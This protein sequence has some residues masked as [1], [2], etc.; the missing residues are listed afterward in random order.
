MVSTRNNALTRAPTLESLDD[1]IIEI[2]ES[3]NAF[4]IAQN[5]VS[6]EINKPKSGEG[7]S[8]PDGGSNTTRRDQDN[9]HGTYKYGWI[10]KIKFPKFSG[11]DVKGWLSR[12]NQF[13][14][15]DDV[16]DRNKV[17]L[18]SM[19]VSLD[20]SNSL[21]LQ[22]DDNNSG[23]LISLK[24]T[25]SENY[26]VWTNAMKIAL[27]A[28]NKMC[29][30]DG[31]CTK[32]AYVTSVS[33]S[34]QWEGCNA[35]VLSWLL[36]SISDDLYL[37]QVYY[38][39]VVEFDILTKL[40]PCTCDAKTELGKHNQL[41]KLMQFLMGL[42]DVYLPIRSSLL[43]QTE[44][45]DVKDAFV[46]VCREESHIG[47]GCFEIIG[48][49]NSFKRNQNG[50][51]SSN[52]KGYSSNN[53][54]VQKN[55]SSMPFTSDQIAKLMSL[56]GDKPGNGIHANM[57]E[58]N[59]IVGHPNGT[60]AKIRKVGNLKLTSN[61]VLFDVLVIPEYCVSL[62]SI[63]KLLRDSQLHVGFDEYDCIIQ[64]LKKENILG[65]GSEAGG[66]YVDV[67]FYETIF[68]YKMSLEKDK[69]LVKDS[70]ELKMFSENDD[71]TSHKAFFDYFQTDSQALSPNDDGGEPS[72]SNIGEEDFSEGNVF[73]NNDVPIHLFNTMESNTLRRFSRQT[74]LP[75]KLNDY[76]LNSKVRYGI[77]KFVNHTWLS[78]EN[79]R[80]IANINMSFKPKSYEEAALDKNWAPKQW[81]NRLFEALIENDF[82]QS[83]HDHSLYTKESGGSFVALLVYV[84]DI[85]LTSNDINEINKVKIFLKSKFKIKD[86]G[87]LKYF[88]GI[89]VLK[90]ETSGL[91][92]SQRKYC[93]ELLHD[94]G[95]LACKPMSTPLPENIILAQ[96]ESKDDK[97]LKN[98]TSY[99]RLIGKLIY[100][101]L[102]RP[103]IS[104]F[105][106]Y[107]SQ[108]MQAPLQSH[109][110]LGL[111]VLKYLKDSP[112]SGVNYEKFEHMSLK[113]YVDS[114]WAKCP[115]TRRSVSG[116]CVF[117]MVVWFCGKAKKQATLSKS[118][119]EA[120]YSAAIQIAA[121]PVMHEKT[122]HFD[123]D[124]HI[125]REKVA[126]VFD[127]P[128]I[129]LKKLKQDGTVK[130][131]QEKFEALLNMVELE[132][133]H[134]ISL[135]LR[136]L[137][138]EIS[139]QFRMF[140]LHTLTEAFYMACK[141]QEQTLTALKSRYTP[142]LPTLVPKINTNVAYGGRT[143]TVHV[144]PNTSFNNP[145]RKRLTQKEYEE[146]RANNLCFYCDK[147]YVFGYKCA[148]QLYLLIVVGDSE[149]DEGI[150]RESR[151][152][153]D[154]CEEVVET[155]VVYEVDAMV[156]PLGACGM[157]L[158]VLWLAN[159][160]D[161]KWNF[162]KLTMA[163]TYHKQKV[164]LRVLKEFKDVF[165]LPTAL[166]PKRSYNHQIQLLPNTLPVNV[167]P[168]RHP[169][170]QKD[171]IEQMKDSSWRMCVDYRQLNKATIKDKFPIPMIEELIDELSGATVFSKL[172]W[173]SCSHQIRM[174]E[175]DI[176]KISFRTHEGHYEFLVM[177][178]GLTNAP[179]TFQSLMNA[180]FKPFL[181][182]FTLVFFDDIL[183]YI[184][185]VEYLRHVILAHG[186]ATDPTKIQAI[187][188][189]PV[190][191]NVKQLRGIWTNE[192]Q[193]AF[194][195]LQ[196]VMISSL[197]LALPDFNK[198]FVVETDACGTGVGQFCNKK[199]KWLPKLL[200]YDYEIDYKKGSDNT[201][202]DA[203]S[204]VD[205]QAELASLIATT[206]TSV[207][208]DKI[209]DIEKE[210]MRTLRGASNSKKHV[211]YGLLEVKQWVRECDICQ[212]Q[213]PDL[214]AS[215]GLL[216]PLPIPNRV[217][218]DISMD[219]VEGLSSSQGKF[220]VFVTVDRFMDSMDITLITRE[221]VIEMLKFHLKRAEDKMKNQADKHKTDMSYEVGDWV[222]LKLQP[223]RQVKVRQNPYHKLSAK[224]LMQKNEMLQQV[225][226][227]GL[228]S[229]QP[230]A[231][232]DRKLGQLNNKAM[233]YI[234]VQWSNGDEEGATWEIYDDVM[235]RFQE[236]AELEDQA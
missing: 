69:F 205:N 19:H 225:G 170:M 180:V 13:F 127:D 46:I 97:F 182:K 66:L 42:D 23:P 154:Y 6:D 121:N 159:L 169:P 55:S 116:Y 234:L 14:K 220:I 112:G 157:V 199:M 173:R 45:P 195:R 108:H 223:Y 236:F 198:E 72:G 119:V 94:F 186:V 194:E 179:L 123:L 181:R 27:Q 166:P 60:T 227:H 92:L 228:L 224:G 114:D 9:R 183:V 47:H 74:K 53:V 86:L 213:K 160:G 233:V 82:K 155:D 230:V 36:S 149:G 89:E 150:L 129:E 221:L 193:M 22:T 208:F 143:N 57:A 101:T 75:P 52:N 210:G 107:L 216:Q 43:T 201:D 81:N 1:A 134:A 156:L 226:R 58:L 54:D 15:I 21:H 137:K 139:L 232:L 37:S 109:M 148:W 209:N 176:I 202:V 76:V 152:G 203:L 65:T 7:T 214:S 98:I 164:L 133:K 146:K 229:V 144:K 25:G 93:L 168:Y 172:D 31:T 106:H 4:L 140:T 211:C 189:W 17:E 51:N 158:G 215:P 171:A 44:L 90:T 85:V 167:R 63:N 190:P 131:Y 59:I 161:I 124:V 30:V 33:L 41:M 96:K 39:N 132:E 184:E 99:Q 50:K 77:D 88:L 12:C 135:F 40:S 128:L 197:V 56:I 192:A 62:L 204:R 73:E 5:K 126:S 145:N 120:E 83:R 35:V 218:S 163:F 8:A 105:V 162:E 222:Y 185:S 111:R 219:F 64:D 16:D 68:P 61:I 130:E 2:R 207:L 49:P 78:V 141:M 95:L 117:L 32:A 29:F 122:K 212:R 217:W 34:N 113:V 165:A 48:Y 138:S 175:D 188:E 38:E 206:I 125:I 24:L 3:M 142:L 91:C 177:P 67:K 20:A 196:Q 104:Y 174:R 178:F 18:V 153:M 235:Q 110:D 100:L 231:I 11:E 79:C 28:R 151:E 136:G 26:R 102:T 84:D 71:L 118:S 80:F 200:G 147:K 10:V 87:E 187:K 103:D 115:V 70:S 191:S